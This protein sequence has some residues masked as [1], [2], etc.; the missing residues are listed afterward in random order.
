MQ[1]QIWE[2]CCLFLTLPLIKT[3]RQIKQK[4]SFSTLSSN[5]LRVTTT[6]IKTLHCMEMLTQRKIEMKLY[7]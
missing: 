3:L 6:K 1:L 4:V 2:G 7:A 5:L